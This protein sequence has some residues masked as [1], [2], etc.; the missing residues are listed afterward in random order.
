MIGSLFL[1][2]LLLGLRHALEADHVAAVATLA[3]RRA[4]LAQRAAVGGAWG[5]GHATSLLAVGAAVL[6]L[7]VA[8]P[9]AL[10]RA[11][12]VGVGFLLVA[13]GARVLRRAYR[14]RVHIHAHRHADGEL[15]LHAHAHPPEAG[16]HGTHAHHHEHPHPPDAVWRALWVGGAH[17]LAGSAA[18][19]L[20]S[21]EAASSTAQAFAYMAALGAG[22]MVGMVALTVVVTL[23]LRASCLRRYAFARGAEFALGAATIAIGAWIAIDSAL[24]FFPEA[25]PRG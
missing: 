16:A 13:L 21:A 18:L 12:E 22:S 7:G 11:C 9:P 17:G 8:M 19:V 2:G 25:T 23:P 20:L 4:S 24:G 5:A 1:L 14:Q 3:R 15:H 10:T 6:L